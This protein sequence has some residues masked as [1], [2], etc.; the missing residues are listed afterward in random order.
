[1]I[2]EDDGWALKDLSDPT[3]PSYIFHD[4]DRQEIIGNIYKNPELFK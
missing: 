3:L 1:V 4:E 2:W